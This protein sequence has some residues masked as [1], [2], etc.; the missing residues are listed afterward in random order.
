MVRRVEMPHGSVVELGDDGAPVRWMAPDGAM[1]ATISEEGV[2]LDLAGLHD[3]PVTVG[4]PLEEHAVLGTVQ[5]IRAVPRSAAEGDEGTI[6]ARVAL[7]DW[8]RPE[9]IPAIDAPAR[10]PIGVGTA[11]LN[12]IALGTQAAGRTI[13]YCG[14]Y[15]TAALW[16]SLL[17]A[18]RVDGD[19]ATAEARFTDGA[20]ERALRGDSSE[21]A[22][23]FV[24][25]PFERL[26]VA[27]R[28]VV[29]LRDGIE[30]LYVGGLAWG[31]TGARR[32]IR[33]ADTVRAVL[34]IGGEPWAE[35]AELAPDGRLL[36]GPRPLPPV[37][38]SVVG[39]AFPPALLDALIEVMTDDEPPLLATAMRE[40]VR[41]L[42]VVWGDPGADVARPIAGVLVVHAGLW[43]R[44]G[45][46][47]A[48]VLAQHL[49][50]AIG[51]PIKQLAQLK[52]ET[53]PIGVALH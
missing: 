44:V 6:V 4:G 33:E 50:A 8:R 45:S 31:S 39:K 48:G 7:T 13:R 41:D 21:V 1:V 14:P 19:P 28:A 22:V 24:P 49:A 38:S 52:L 27:P 40:V 9:H 12:V 32:L 23:D 17:E 30:R 36:S 26:Q 20:F 10:L 25:A 47:P 15:P 53:V 42:S 37:R 35:V 51:P 34:W 3:R 43:E 29:H 2:R 11:L 5:V 18:F 16:T 46:G